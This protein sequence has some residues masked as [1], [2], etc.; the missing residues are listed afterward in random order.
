MRGVQGGRGEGGKVFPL[1]V[2]NTRRGSANFSPKSTRRGLFGR[3][4]DKIG[5]QVDPQ[6][7]FGTNK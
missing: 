3:K 2:V 4:N 1:Q 6:G 5:S 7:P